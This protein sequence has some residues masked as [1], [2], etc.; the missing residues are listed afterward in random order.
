MSHSGYEYLA[1]ASVV[2][3]MARQE[4]TPMQ[5]HDGLLRTRSM[6]SRSWRAFCLISRLH[7]DV[8]ISAIWS[9]KSAIVQSCSLSTRLETLTSIRP[10]NCTE[11]KLKPETSVQKYVSGLQINYSRQTNKPILRFLLSLSAK[12]RFVCPNGSS[13]FR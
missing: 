4:V 7:M 9:T 2:K 6:Y 10:C 3:P 13:E 8:L 12:H 11:S 1:R 5:I